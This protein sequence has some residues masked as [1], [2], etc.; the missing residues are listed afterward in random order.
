M[1]PGIGALNP[2]HLRAEG[3]EIGQ[4]DD[5]ALAAVH[6]FNELDPTA[7]GGYVQRRELEAEAPELFHADFVFDGTPAASTT[8]TLRPRRRFLSHDNCA[9][10]DLGQ[11]RCDGSSWPVGIRP[12]RH[13]LHAIIEV[14]ALQ[15]H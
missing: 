6:H 2:R 12:Q 11:G 13:A 14:A 5:H 10:A 1:E 4:A 3:L 8:A 15:T 7:L 9:I